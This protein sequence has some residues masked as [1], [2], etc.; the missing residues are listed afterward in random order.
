[1]DVTQSRSPSTMESKKAQLMAQFKERIAHL[2]AMYFQAIALAARC[3]DETSFT[4]R[5]IATRCRERLLAQMQRDKTEA[6]RQYEEA[7]ENLFLE[8]VAALSKT[9]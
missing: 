5:A 6:G 4:E 7:L 2:D 1:M 9:Q 3:F 8:S